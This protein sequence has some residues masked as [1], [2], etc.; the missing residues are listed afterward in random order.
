MSSALSNTTAAVRIWCGCIDTDNDHNDFVIIGPIPRNSSAPPNSCASDPTRI[1]GLGTATPPSLEVTASTLLAV[2]LTPATT[3]PSTGL[4]VTADLTSIGASAT[5]QFFDDG[6][7]GDAIAGDNVFSVQAFVGAAIPTGVEY[8]VAK[9]TDNQNRSANIPITLTVE[10]PTCGVEY[11]NVKTGTDADAAS[12]NLNNVIQTTVNDLRAIP[13]PYPPIGDRPRGA[14][15]QSATRIP[16]TEFT[17]FQVPGTLTFYK[18]ETDVDYH[19]VLQD[20]AGNTIIGEVP[21]PA[22]VGAGSPFAAGI[23]IARAKVDARLTP[24]DGFQSANL[25]V[26]MKGVGFF[27]ILHGQTG[28]APNGIELHPLLDVNF[29]KP[30]ATTLLSALNPSQFGQTVSI[31]ATVSNGGTP[32]PTGQV[33]LLDAGGTIGTAN[34]DPNGTATFNLSTLSTGSHPLTASYAG[35][36]ASAPST[37]APLTQVVNK[38]DQTITFGALGGMTFGD[39]DFAVSATASSG[40]PV[41]FSIVSGPA[42]VAGNLVHITGAGAITVRASQPGD[43]NYNAAVNVDQSFVVAKANQTISFAA[44][45]NKTFGDAPFAVNATG[46]ASTQTVQF[47]ASGACSVSGNTVTI[48]STGS[49]AVTASQSGDNNYNAAADVVRS[50]AINKASQSTVTVNAPADATFGQTGLMATASGGSGTGA[51]SFSAAGSTACTVD[52]ATGVLVITAGAGTCTITAS[53]A[54]DTNYN[55]SAASAPVTVNILKAT[56]VA[57]AASSKNPSTFGDSVSFTA[58]VSPAGATGSVQFRIDGNNFGSPVALINGSASSSATA[59]LSAGNHS[60]SA[61]YG[62]DNNFA[63]STAPLTQVV[64]QAATASSIVS[65]LNPSAFGQVVVFTATVTSPGGTPTGT[66]TFKDGS[67]SLG[68]VALDAS[69]HASFATPALVAGTHSI[70]AAYGGGIN[71]IISTSAPLG[72]LV[73]QAN[74]ATSL[75]SSNNPSSVGQSVS[76][77]ATTLA[78]APGAGIPTG[79]VTFKD[80][81]TVLGTM[82][83]DGSGQATFATS[84][85]ALGVHSI[86]ATYSGDANFIASMSSPLSQ[87][88]FVF[89]TGGGSF[90]IGDLEAVVGG[91]VTFTGS[92]W[93]KANNMSSGSAPSSFK[94]FADSISSSP[95]TVGGTWTGGPGNSSHPPGSV[96]SYMA[97]L[98]SSAVTKSGSTITGNIVAIVIVKTDSSS[99]DTGTVVAII[100]P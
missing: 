81:A 68:S 47:S 50:F 84:T 21:S 52:A 65:S 98:V 90:V 51:Y 69:G 26:Q 95:A 100:A 79:A 96:P 62:G 53:R 38:A 32:N 11:W 36:S 55:A 16:S 15:G 89:L 27:D 58:Q 5:Q 80:G 94:G 9:V 48:N 12:V 17:V 83:L 33:T 75:T 18:L 66:V 87:Q 91:Q 61:L 30:T 54:G 3:P 19:M 43:T 24:A 1:T 20:N 45:P 57:S 59:L 49:C 82:T 44:L 46:G 34:L 74:T 22:C 76:F 70:T 2:T 86:T 56:A 88:V 25:P 63:G 14:D 39:P 13:I 40:L 60:V 93:D 28:V 73:A 23:A 97:V 99:A 35:D 8:L 10:S 77:T 64:N 37:S 31:T 72:Q 42:T 6:T 92:Q 71:F 29:T 7:H 85:L 78:V 67:A 41:S 4:S